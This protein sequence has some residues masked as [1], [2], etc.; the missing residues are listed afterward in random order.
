MNVI[1]SRVHHSH[2]HRHQ[3]RPHQANAV[4]VEGWFSVTVAAA[5]T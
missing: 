1:L 5:A 2:H 3:Y 4:I